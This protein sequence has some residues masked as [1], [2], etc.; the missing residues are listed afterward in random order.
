MLDAV[1]DR[2][3][4]D[5]LHT[6]RIGTSP[7]PRNR[8]MYRSKSG[9]K[10]CRMTVLLLYFSG[11]DGSSTSFSACSMSASASVP[12]AMFQR[13]NS[14]LSSAFFSCLQ[15]PKLLWSVLSALNTGKGRSPSEVLWAIHIRDLV[16]K[17]FI[18][19]ESILQ[20]CWP[21]AKSCGAPP[22]KS[23]TAP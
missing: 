14:F 17:I 21:H 19:C 7:S 6:K 16:P 11:I 8:K 22:W 4:C 2:L 13:T 5:S 9:M 23:W 10:T 12:M 18:A 20:R 3:S 15:T 1:S